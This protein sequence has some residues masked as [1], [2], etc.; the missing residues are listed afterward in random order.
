MYKTGDILGGCRLLKECGAGAFGSVFLAE[1]ETTGQ[2][3]ALKILPKTGSRWENELAALVAYQEKCRHANLMRIYHV[4]HD[5]DCIFYT[6]DAA[7]PLDPDGDYVP[8]TLGNRL[9]RQKRLAP[10]EIRPMLEELLNALEI[11]HGAGLLHRDIKPSNILVTH[12][13]DTVKLIDFGLSDSASHSVLKIPAGT[14]IYTAPEVLK[15]AEADV[16]SEIYSLGL[17]IASLGA[18]HRQVVRKCCEARPGRR[19]AS[20]AD[21]KKALHSRWPYISGVLFILLIA[22]FALYPYVSKW[23][24]RA[25]VAAAPPEPVTVPVDTSALTPADTLSMDPPSS[26]VPSK[27]TKDSPAKQPASSSDEPVDD[28]LIDELFRQATELFE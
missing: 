25:D 13:G 9:R 14:A 1:N 23:L 12:K 26:V 3:V 24:S 17:V 15:G 22:A 19:Y 21:V 16:R 2:R 20:V 27:R 4:G 7:D 5:D 18:R 11:L 8:D 28:G 10:E 6:M